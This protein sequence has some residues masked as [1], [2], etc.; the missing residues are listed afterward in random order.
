MRSKNKLKKDSS[1]YGIIGLGRFGTSLAKSLADAGQEIVV[2]DQIESKVREMRQYTDNAFVTSDLSRENLEEMGIQNCTTVV[3]CIGDHLDVNILTAL[4]VV[5]LGVPN[6]I[7]K[8]MSKEHGDV[9]EKIGA[10]VVF[11]ERDMAVRLA[12][13]LTAT[14][15]LEYISLSNEIEISELR[16]PDRYVG[17]SVKDI[18]IR[19]EFGLNIIAIEHSKETI[20]SIDPNYVIC[21]TDHL[22]VI[23]RNEDVRRFESQI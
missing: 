12:K 14:S 8:A 4:N 18:G 3:I 20:T 19:Q 9:L 22:V 11:P 10:Q 2:I 5:S 6:V 17:M 13:R 16:T 23:G 7:A 21:E 1:T 15:L